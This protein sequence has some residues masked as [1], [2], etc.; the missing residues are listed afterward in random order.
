MANSV[1]ITLYLLRKTSPAQR[2]VLHDSGRFRE[3]DLLH[4]E[5]ADWHLYVSG[6][7]PRETSWVKSLRPIIGNDDLGELQSI[8]SSAVLLVKYQQRTFAVT[9]GQGYHAI[10]PQ[11]IERGFGLR[12]TANVIA[13][14]KITSADT[15]GMSGSGKNQRTMLSTASE[16]YALGIE[17]T[18]EWVR[19]LSGKASEQNFAT[20]AAGADSLRLT[21]KDFSLTKLPSKLSSIWR[22]YEAS[23]YKKDFGFLDNF[24]RVDRSDPVIADLNE[25]VERMVLD[26]DSSLSFAAPDPFEQLQ[27]DSY[28]LKYRKTRT[29]DNLSLDEM[30]DAIHDLASPSRG[31]LRR[32]KVYAYGEDGN[33]VDKCYDLF[34]Y[35]QAE[36]LRGDGRFVL[37]AGAWFRVS[38]D[39]VQEIH[40]YV[41]QI[42]DITDQLILP[43][44]DTAKLQAD[45]TDK[46]LE[47]SYNIDVA[48][49][50]DIALLDKR[51]LAIGGR[52]QKIEICDLLTS[53]KKL[54]C[55]KRATKSS[56]LSHLFAQGGVSASLMHEPSYGKR[57]MDALRTVDS[58]ATYGISSDWT[59]VYAIATNKVG[60]LAESL[61]F[62]SQ[63]NL[64]THARDIRSRGFRVALCRI[65]V[66]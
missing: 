14:N 39:Y 48:R 23:D 63:T 33:L 30:Y 64:V 58:T 52:N 4:D 5:D 8:S 24:I 40:K 7:P 11:Y 9:F 15:R 47:G 60:K 37:T 51:N 49:R 61:F 27:V 21:I 36:I 59:F 32:V 18:E 55:V 46:T 53:D 20:S 45:D 44:W 3:I 16:L 65:Q 26:R 34:D 17:P 19:Q 10:D 1:R 62:F 25:T 66:V 38:D 50:A 29:V 54:I 12:V 28:Q 41:A 43:V 13:A 56:T 6:G 35:I 31:V 57:L 2:N 22:K 42:E